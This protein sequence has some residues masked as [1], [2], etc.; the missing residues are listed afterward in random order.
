MDV[1]RDVTGR[2]RLLKSEG[3]LLLL[4]LGIFG[5]NFCNKVSH[6]VQG[7]KLNYEAVKDSFTVHF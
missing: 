7:R 2:I 3:L 5:G 6:L 4:Y 1:I